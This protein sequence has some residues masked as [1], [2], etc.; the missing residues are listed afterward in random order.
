MIS[1]PAGCEPMIERVLY[2]MGLLPDAVSNV[3]MS[4]VVPGQEIELHT[5]RSPRRVHVPIMTNK[6]AWFCVEDERI[7][8]RVGSAY[9]IDTRRLHGVLNEGQCDRIH[10]MF[11]VE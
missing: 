10:L 6:Q 9:E 7:N 5:D 4:R 1:D 11:D 3:L 2:C 8:M